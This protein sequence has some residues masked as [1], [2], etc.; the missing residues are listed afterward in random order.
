MTIP[1][2]LAASSD[3]RVS[4]PIATLAAMITLLFLGTYAA[5][6]LTAGSKVL[7]E[8]FGWDYR[9]GTLL[10]TASVV[11]YC[12]SGGI[13]AS[14][15][16]DAAQAGVMLLSMLFLLVRALVEIGGFA[17]LQSRLAAIDP[18]LVAWQP[19]NL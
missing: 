19:Q 13:R 5:A 12:F 10:G 9:T 6:Q 1:S 3:R 15:W 7:H 14:I 2:F 8:L 18:T 11:I 17:A 16:T 4:R